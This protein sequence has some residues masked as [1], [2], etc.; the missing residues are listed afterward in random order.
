[1]PGIH[2]EQKMAR[3]DVQ[4]E[5]STRYEW[6]NEIWYMDKAKRERK[7]WLGNFPVCRMCLE[8]AGECG[9]DGDNGS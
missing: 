8:K 4:E 7:C 1:M 9:L 3:H 6:R 5:Y 2:D